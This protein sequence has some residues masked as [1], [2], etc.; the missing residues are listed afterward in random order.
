VS[1]YG[2]QRQQIAVRAYFDR[3]RR[4]ASSQVLIESR[5]V[6]VTLRDEY[7]SGINWRSMFGGDLN[8]GFDAVPGASI[9]GSAGINPRSTVS[10]FATGATVPQQ[11][12][13]AV[14]NNI[15]G[16]TN[17]AAIV[18]FLETFG[19]VRA[20]SSPRLTVLN[21]QT[22]ILKVAQNQVYFTSTVTPGQQATAT[23]AATPTVVSST[24]NTI[25][26]GVVMAVQPAIDQDNGTV[27]L[28]L[29]PTISRIIGNVADPGV[30][31]AAQALAGVNVTSLIPVVEVRE[32]DSV[33]RV[34]SGAVAV[35]GGLMRDE[36]TN[37][38]D[39]IP[40]ASQIPL[41]GNLFKARTQQQQ[42]TELVILL[43]AT[44]VENSAPDAADVD[45]YRRYQRDPR[46]VIN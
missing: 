38:D 17:L 16:L 9:V 26:V 4:Q 12:F 15:G 36:A 32:I 10:P 28:T 25:P 27:L 22:A 44:I 39:G 2:T 31:I 34:R 42:V 45:L 13:T 14:F 19:T 37:Q 3:L 29:R 1:I 5:I 46:P 6:E 24:A 23:S 21:N 40:G 33:L 41:I 7:R 35:L 43:R 18:Q 8:V 30:T 11:A 20:L